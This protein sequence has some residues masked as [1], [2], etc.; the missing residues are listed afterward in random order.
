MLP[1]GAT[2]SDTALLITVGLLFVAIAFLYQLLQLATLLGTHTGER[3]LMVFRCSLFLHV[4]R[5]SLS[6]HDRRGIGDSTYRIH[7]DASN[8]RD[9]VEAFFP[10]LAALSMFVAMLCVTILINWQLAL[11]ALGITPLLMAIAKVFGK[12][13]RSQWREAR[14]LRAEGLSVVQEALAALQVVNAF[15]QERREA[16]RFLSLDVGRIARPD[17]HCLHRGGAWDYW[18]A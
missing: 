11:V 14:D 12:R 10:L 3:L 16:S 5:L 8:L 9:L 4:Q 13:L 18:L 7:Y 17:A 1:E 15:G 6:Y 2:E